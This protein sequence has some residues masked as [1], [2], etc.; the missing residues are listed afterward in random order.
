[1]LMSVTQMELAATCRCVALCINDCG[2]HGT[3]LNGTCSCND[4][5]YGLECS[6]GNL[7]Y[8][9]PFCVIPCQSITSI[10]SVF[11]CLF[12]MK[13]DVKSIVVVMASV[14]YQSMVLNVIV[15]LVMM[16]NHVS[17]DLPHV[18]LMV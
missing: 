16:E 10:T 9:S 11:V 14:I 5:W 6:I 8:P 2:T 17:M 13:L 3:C 18:I 4:G 12:V 7:Y 15:T 1:M